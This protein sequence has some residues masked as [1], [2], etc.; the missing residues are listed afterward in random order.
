MRESHEWVET[1]A[2][3]DKAYQVC[4]PLQPD[5]ACR[6]FADGQSC[7]TH[8]MLSRV[9]MISLIIAK[10]LA[11]R[12]LA[13]SCLAHAISCF[14]ALRGGRERLGGRLTECVTDRPRGRGRTGALPRIRVSPVVGCRVSFWVSLTCD[15]I[16]A[17]IPCPSRLACLSVPGALRACSGQGDVLRGQRE[18]GNFWSCGPSASQSPCILCRL[19]SQRTS[20]ATLR[21]CR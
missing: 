10:R 1:L 20:R 6:V 16:V 19:K 14:V 9:A 2:G 13:P 21:L 17:L 18:A 15:A 4:L 5:P 3:D 11:A 7:R 8:A 12:P